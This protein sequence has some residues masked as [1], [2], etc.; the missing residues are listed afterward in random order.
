MKLK[1][2]PAFVLFNLVL[3]SAVS[4]LYFYTNGFFTDVLGITFT[5]LFIPAH[6]G[7]FA[8]VF[9]L[10]CLTLY[11][12][13]NK[14]FG[15]T[16]IILGTLAG[17]FF[18]VDI[19]IFMQYRFH[20][21]LAMVQLFLGPAGR[22]IFVFPLGMWGMIAGFALGLILIEWGL[23][24]LSTKITLSLKKLLLICAV[25]LLLFVG[26]NAMYA[27]GKFMM[28]PSIMAQRGVLPYALPLSANSTLRKMG[29]EPK[30]QPF[31]MPEQGNLHYPLAPVSCAKTADKNV[32]I[33]L[34]ESWR[35]D[36][37]SPITMPKLTA[38]TK[39]GLSYFAN[40]L[41]GG[42][43]TEAGV[44]SLFYSLPYSYWNDFTSRHLPPFVLSHAQ[45]MGYE[46]AIY[47]SGK[48]NSPTFHQNI[49][50][51][52][53]NLRLSSV[54]ETKWERDINAVEDFEK[55]L[56]SQKTP[57]FGFI[58]LD[59][60][61]ASSYPPED[62]KF[63]PSA[64]MNYLLLGN[65]TDP[66]PYVNRYKNSIYFTD[67]ML[68]RIL[69]DLEKRN[70]LDNT[71]VIITG[72]H[73]QEF[74]DTHHNNWGHNSNFAAY[75]THVPL[76]VWYKGGPLAGQR[77]YTTSHYDIVPTIA[78]YVYQC[79]S[80]MEDYTI[81]KDLF[82]ASARPFVIISSYTTKAIRTGD[83][84]TILDAYGNV[85]KYDQ[86]YKPIEDGADPAAIK[87][88]LKTFAKFYY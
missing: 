24:K 39:K 42:N 78:K 64:E 73:G 76:F 82:D 47:S 60:P 57:F 71:M 6:I 11:K 48:L 50:A 87:E 36:S 66:T 32:L 23:C 15:L 22:E 72:D 21:S 54:G 46:P 63:T 33:I 16:C 74:N 88:A 14:F 40:H 37:F 19:V 38:W 30:Q 45:Q 25:W 69:T 5:A 70:L 44:F 1:N 77:I 85:Q 31:S 56:D 29:F 68:D 13:T 83:K 27:W 20:L 41:S 53:P 10:V 49:F 55:F 52:V 61:H 17:F 84:L 79:T 81:G 75:Q 43:A 7:L 59:A 80:P 8:L 4:L 67:K 86:D 18:A 58:F 9:A 62:E 2:L 28:V 65:N 12:L 35:S 26:Y 34:V 3:W 51:G